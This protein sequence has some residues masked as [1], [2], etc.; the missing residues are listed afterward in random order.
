MS[1]I[2]T[3]VNSL[4][5]CFISCLYCKFTVVT[6]ACWVIFLQYI[7][8]FRSNY[9]INLQQS[10]RLSSVL[11]LHLPPRG[12]GEVIR[13][14]FAI[15]DCC[16]IMVIV[17]VIAISLLVALGSLYLPKLFID[18]FYCYK[19]QAPPSTLGRARRYRLTELCNKVPIGFNGTPHIYP[20]NCPFFDF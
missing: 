18:A 7:T 5:E 19:K 4:N 15:K 6:D 20:Q 10:C 12:Q 17:K 8:K 1:W 16:I 13:N 11:G 14:R 9:V 3:V 2:R